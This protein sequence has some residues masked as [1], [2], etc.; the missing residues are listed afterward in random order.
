MNGVTEPLVLEINEQVKRQY[1]TYPYPDYS[2]FIPLRTQEAYASHSL[3]SGQ[4]LK[5]QG[6]TPAVRGESS[7]SILIA[8]SG[9]VLPYVLSFWEPETHTI[10]AV[11]LSEK[12]IQR[13]RLRSTFRPHS[14]HW[15]AG[16]LEDQDFQIPHA[17]AHI[18]SYGVLHHMAKPKDAIKRLAENLEANGTFR[19]M[20]YNSETRHWIHQLQASFHL[21]G[22]SAYESRD[23]NRALS[24]LK[25][26]MKVSP[27]Y[28]ERLAPMRSGIF[29]HSAR[30]VDTFFHAHEGRTTFA[31]WLEAFAEADLEPIGLFDRYAELDDLPNPLLKFPSLMEMDQRV[32]DRRFE[33]NFEFFLAKKSPDRTL[34][35]RRQK[36]PTR[37][38]L[39]AP[40]AAWFTY[41]ETSGISL[42]LRYKLWHAFV[43]TM[44]EVE[45]PKI[46]RLAKDIKPE[47]LQRLARL[48]A[49]FPSQFQSEE[50]KNLLLRPLHDKME[51]P[52]FA[53]EI[54]L[55]SELGLRKLLEK[56]ALETGR[57]PETVD[58]VMKR[59]EAG[60]RI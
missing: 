52:T 45:A 6:I 9:D 33:N 43:K 8:G 29:H 26:L 56:I 2:L 53:R 21:L 11:D 20:V 16:N 49:I 5:E 41:T 3:F 32:S 40:P 28:K 1:E 27:R 46:D 23:L 50:L 22:L 15:Q 42:T 58:L 38:R 4:L 24:I 25:E 13:A 54:T 7:S 18:D 60:Q 59:L 47:A 39:K 37:W 44:N 48:G 36:Q 17:L 35:D 34:S 51:P 19:I 31:E 14:F 57:K 10:H 30:F 55:Q 12:N